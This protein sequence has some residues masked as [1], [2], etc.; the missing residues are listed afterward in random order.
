MKSKEDYYHV[1]EGQL[2]LSNTNV[3]QGLLDWLQAYKASEGQELRT[4][5][6]TIAAT[7]NRYQSDNRQLPPGPNS[8]D[9]RAI[10]R[11]AEAA[12]LAWQAGAL[13]VELPWLIRYLQFCPESKSMVVE[14]LATWCA[15]Q[16][17]LIE[18][19]KALEA[20]V[21]AECREGMEAHAQTTQPL[22]LIRQ[23]QRNRESQPSLS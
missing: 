17:R 5:A 22:N 12:T 14:D 7:L 20:V 18:K 3:S 13:D 8:I 16:G 10:A 19:L 6:T 23:G 4:H 1:I 9:L 11:Q 21:L 15:A 2:Q